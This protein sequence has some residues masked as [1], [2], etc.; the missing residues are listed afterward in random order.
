MDS[1][2]VILIV[3]LVIVVLVRGPKTLPQIGSMLGRG[4]KEVRKETSEFQKER[5]ATGGDGPPAPP[6]A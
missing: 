3:I 1:L 6:P 4:V 2:L 5:D